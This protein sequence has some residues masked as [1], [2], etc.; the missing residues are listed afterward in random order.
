MAARVPD[1][2]PSGRIFATGIGAFLVLYV[3]TALWV[4]V[5][6]DTQS[7]ASDSDQ[8]PTTS[9]VPPA[10]SDPPRPPSTSPLVE[11]EISFDGDSITLTGRVASS[12]DSRAVLRT[13]LD[14]SHVPLIVN[15]LE[16]DPAVLHSPD[17]DVV[18]SELELVI[19]AGAD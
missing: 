14:H 12:D 7:A 1:P 4:V 11:I 3:L 19:E 17:L 2:L 16:V 15:Q 5:R 6:S 9:S 18:E 8:S 13:V 10:T